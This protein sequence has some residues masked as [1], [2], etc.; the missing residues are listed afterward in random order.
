LGRRSGYPRFVRPLPGA[1]ERQPPGPRPW[2]RADAGEAQ[3]RKILR[4]TAELIAKRGYAGTK[5]DTIVKRAHVGYGTFNK[6][7]A[8][9]DEAYRTL[10]EETYDLHSARIAEA[11]GD[12]EDERPWADRVA[13]A[14]ATF[15]RA[16][17]EDPVLWRACIVEART[18]GPEVNRSNEAAIEDLGKILI[19][20]RRQESAPANLPESIETT[21]AGGIVWIAYQRL[22]IG[23]AERLPEMLSDAL[24]FVL[25]PYLGEGGARDAAQRN[26]N[27][28]ID[29]Q[30]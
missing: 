19:P 10:F 6:F 28:A 3:R 16:I 22:V 24:Q 2:S 15:Y 8:D 30:F 20:G 5:T 9:K 13:A 14:I 23:E 12:A 17:A 25:L 18:A 26:A 21:L 4:V 7:F 1:E 29:L 27:L 11:F